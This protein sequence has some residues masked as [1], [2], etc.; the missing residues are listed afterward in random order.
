MTWPKEKLFKTSTVLLAILLGFSFY[1]FNKMSN[2]KNIITLPYYSYV[3]LKAHGYDYITVEGTLASDGEGEIANELNTNKFICDLLKN[4][5]ELIQ[6]E[7]FNDSLLALYNETFDISSW[8]SNFIVFKTQPG[9]TPC[10]AWTYRIDRLKK[11]LMG[12]R[13]KAPDY[14]YES[15]TGIGSEKF[16]VKVVNGQDV[17]NRLRGYKN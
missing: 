4:T 3:D 12:V 2:V 15:C 9:N 6:A 1:F 14:N 17:I 10:V 11:E 7:I 8:D 16:I 13:E 5:C